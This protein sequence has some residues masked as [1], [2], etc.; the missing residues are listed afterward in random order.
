MK[1]SVI[2][3]DFLSRIESLDLHIGCPM[4]GYFGGNRRARSYGSTVEFADFR[5]Y[6]PG[7][8]LRRIDWNIYGR[9]EKYFVKLYVDER[10]LH[11]HIYVDCS[12][13]MACGEPDKSFTALRMAAAI[14]YLSIQAMDR[15]SFRMMRG[16]RSQD[17]CSTVFGRE[18]FYSAADKLG[19]SGF[20][21]DTDI[22]EAVK[23]C[24]EVG[25]GNGISYIISDFLTDSDWKG[26][27]DYLLY[28]RRQVRL[29]QVLSPEEM[30][31]GMSGKMLLLDTE[32][33]GPEDY[34]NRKYEI[35][36]SMIKAYMQAFEWYQ[37]DVAS[38]CR[39]R[40]VG[41]MT[42]CTNEKVEE[43]LYKKG[44]ETGIIA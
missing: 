32:A 16:K 18:S 21:G 33:E 13:S 19:R 42:V 44:F 25:R 34:R 31:P 12:A 1:R 41:Y 38:F 24:E 6:V 20:G 4:D 30:S 14:G 11:S 17:L 26:A 7:D 22:C 28:N 40:Q 9:F 43:A 37:N 29:I 8:D 15:V 2:D 10:Q 35:N 5:E 3:G 23:S 27:V 36:R 39:S